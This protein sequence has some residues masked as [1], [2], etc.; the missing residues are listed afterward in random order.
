MRLTEAQ[1]RA[2]EAVLEKGDRVEIIPGPGGTAKI[3]RVRRSAVKVN[4]DSP[5]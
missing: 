2:I 4:P 5:A 3:L 1:R